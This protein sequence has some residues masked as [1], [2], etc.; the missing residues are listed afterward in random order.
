MLISLGTMK[1]RKIVTDLT[2]SDFCMNCGHTVKHVVER[3][4]VYLAFF[5][6][7]T[8]PLH[9]RYSVKCPACTFSRTINKSEA[10]DFC[11]E[12]GVSEG[13]LVYSES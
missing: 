9:T 12:T 13:S 10:K 7:P 2:G 1:K 6:I 4:R 11:S 5:L 3:E 8:I